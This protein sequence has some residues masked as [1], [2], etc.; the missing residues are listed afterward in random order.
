MGVVS[1]PTPELSW[2]T[3]SRKVT[4][5]LLASENRISQTMFLGQDALSLNQAKGVFRLAGRT[6]GEFQVCSD[7]V[8][9]GN[10]LKKDLSQLI[11]SLAPS[12]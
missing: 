2:H 12:L 8:G 7:A 3:E 4:N 5:S 10:V 9:G 1:E 6:Y 11:Q